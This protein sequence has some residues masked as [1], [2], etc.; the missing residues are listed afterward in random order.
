MIL[1][2]SVHRLTTIH[3]SYGDAIIRGCEGMPDEQRPFWPVPV[4][5]ADD[6]GHGAFARLRPKS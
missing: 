5:K 1:R 4:C 3:E 6:S 2:G